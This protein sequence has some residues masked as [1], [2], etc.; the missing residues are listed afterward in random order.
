MLEND[1]LGN[2]FAEVITIK[3]LF[4]SAKPSAIADCRGELRVLAD[5]NNLPIVSV[6]HY[7]ERNLIFDYNKS[8][9]KLELFLFGPL[10]AWSNNTNWNNI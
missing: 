3:T 8:D 10:R 4:A 2:F 7:V 9:W 6:L 1:H 5:F